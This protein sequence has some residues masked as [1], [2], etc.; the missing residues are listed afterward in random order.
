MMRI[1]PKWIR[2]VLGV[3][4]AQKNVHPKMDTFLKEC[5]RVNAENA[6]ALHIEP[7]LAQAFMEEVLVCE[8]SKVETL[9][10][11]EPALVNFK[12]ALGETPLHR[13]AVGGDENSNMI[14]RLLI[15]KGA[16]VTAKDH[17]ACTPLHLAAACR[18]VE[19]AK[20]LI[21]HGADIRARTDNGSEPIH[22]VTD[23]E[24]VELL[25]SH[26]ADINARS[27]FGETPLAVMLR[28]HAP[29]WLVSFTR[30]KGG[31]L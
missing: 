9:I 21:D 5:D 16:D 13:A 14:A 27:N 4:E 25:L 22:F 31:E 19:T 11:T 2:R 15:D 18:Y 1:L 17:Q 30:K 12:D 29:D 23:R 24:M 7:A 3:S 28:T 20:M 6:R 8:A 26:G 10:S